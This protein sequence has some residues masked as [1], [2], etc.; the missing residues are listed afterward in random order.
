MKKFLDQKDSIVADMLQGYAAA[1]PQRVRLK[2]KNILCR[3]RKKAEGKVGVLIGNGSGHE[4]GMIDL[5][6][7]GL[8]DVNVCGRIFTAPPPLEM[9]EGIKEAYCGK[10]V[11]ILVSSHAGDILNAKMAVMLAK[12]EGIDARMVVLWDDISSAPKGK[13][14]ERR[15]TAGLFFTFKI[16]CAAAEEGWEIDELIRLAEKVRDNTRTISAAASGG[17]HPE[18]GIHTFV[19]PEDEIEVGMGVHG[20]AGS[21]RMKMPTAKEISEYMVKALAEDKPFLPGDS[22]M[23]L[24]NNSGATTRMELLIL[25]RDIRKELLDRGLSA[26]RCWIGTYVTTQEAAGFALSL[27]KADKELLHFYDAPCDS[28]LFEGR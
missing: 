9:L 20:E 4:P 12:A 19:L 8:F 27:C 25:Y 13:E 1:Y 17:T 18:T 22:V 14:K 11:L 16:V 2:G 7:E 10:E 5:V 24:L 6:G 23:V 3:A 28:I 21:G 26:V 15:G